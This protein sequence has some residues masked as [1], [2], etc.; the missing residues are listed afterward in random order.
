MKLRT[1]LYKR[2]GLGYID[3]LTERHMASQTLY[4]YQKGNIFSFPKRGA[5]FCYLSEWA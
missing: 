1:S 4:L 5:N 2:V 3:V